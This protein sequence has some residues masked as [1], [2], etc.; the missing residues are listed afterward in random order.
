MFMLLWD[1]LFTILGKIVA[2]FIGLYFIRRLSLAYRLI[3][4]QVFI[5]II[6]ELAGSYIA[7]VLNQHNIWLFNY[8]WLADMWLTGLA[9]YLLISNKHLKKWVPRLLIIATA[10][11]VT[12]VI[13]NGIDKQPLTALCLMSI[14][15]AIIYF[16][17]L[18]NVLFNSRQILKSPEFWLSLALILYFSCIIPF[19]GLFNYLYNTNPK[20]LGQLFQI[21]DILNF[22]R[23]PLVAL[24]FYLYGIQQKQKTKE[25]IIVNSQ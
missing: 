24:S 8:Y 20:L 19:W 11:W 5:A 14:I 21:I 12:T 10:I 15:A 3:L 9:G 16:A 25:N 22:V 4:I 6:T 17:V 13:T 23:Y 1:L 7:H 2:I 18:I